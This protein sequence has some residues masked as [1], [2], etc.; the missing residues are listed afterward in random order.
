[1]KHLKHPLK[2]QQQPAPG[3]HRKKHAAAPRWV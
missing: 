3:S 1:L 2:P